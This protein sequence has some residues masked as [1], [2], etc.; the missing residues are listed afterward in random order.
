MSWNWKLLR[1]GAFMLD[2]G[3]MFGIVP[4]PLWT[5]L[6]TP[7]EKNRIPMQTN[8]LLL[9]GEGRVVLIETGI[10][11]KF[12]A[13]KR[14][15]YAM[16]DRCILDALGEAGVDPGSITDVVVSHLHFDHA[17]GLTHLDGSGN[18][19]S[20]FPNA[21]IHTQRTEW[22]DA[23]ANKS[24]M[25]STYLRDHL[26]PVREQ[27]R[28]IEGAGEVLPGI[29]VEPLPGHTWGQQGVFFEQDSGGTV[30]FPGDLIP[31]VHHASP[32]YGMA[33][34]VLPYE[35]MLQKGRFLDRA[36]AEGW[37][38]ALDHE[39]GDPIRRVVRDTEKPGRYLLESV[40]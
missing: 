28:T 29:R 24:T 19:V 7:D 40:G 20:S 16:E 37:T 21:V 30:V 25:H 10:G 1:A 15:I 12:D 32:T 14:A 18:A 33:Y 17:G 35:S 8:C 27:I 13:K 36:C 2:G 4:K 9:E 38:L 5:R 31:T 34:D 22:E 23:L 26:D 3:A 39:V 6:V 11:G